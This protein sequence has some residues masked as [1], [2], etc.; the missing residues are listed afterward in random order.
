MNVHC[1]TAL[2]PKIMRS[3]TSAVHVSVAFQP[4]PGMTPASAMKEFRGLWD[5]GATGSVISKRVVAACGLVPTGMVQVSTAGGMCLANT[6][7]VN[8]GLPNGLG[9]PNL[10]VTEADMGKIDVL[11]GM[12][13]ISM[14]DFAV[15][16]HDGK[17][18]FSFRIP[19]MQRVDFGEQIRTAKTRAAAATG[20][21]A[22]TSGTQPPQAPRPKTIL[23]TAL[24]DSKRD[25]YSK[26]PC[27]SGLNY[28]F[29]CGKA[30]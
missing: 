17:S 21:K 16:H 1:F 3:I 2:A 5:T 12:D 22:A 20:F 24:R 29:C 19:S 30:A 27:N 25:P 15:T 26:C 9:V 8:F 11:I 4:G 7:L 23:G 28:K 18:C 10:T 6:Y 14:G 13:I